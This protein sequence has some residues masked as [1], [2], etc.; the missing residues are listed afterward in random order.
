MSK[1]TQKGTP[2]SSHSILFG[3]LTLVVATL[4][5]TATVGQGKFMRG[6][7]AFF[8]YGGGNMQSADYHF[9]PWMTPNYGD[10]MKSKSHRDNQY[11]SSGRT[12]YWMPTDNNYSSSDNTNFAMPIRNYESSSD[13]TNF[14]MPTNSNDSYSDHTN[15]SMPTGSQYPSSDYSMSFGT[16]YPASDSANYSMSSGSEYSSSDYSNYSMSSGSE[17]SSSEYSSSDYSNYSMPTGSDYSS[18]YGMDSSVT[19]YESFMSSV[20]SSMQNAVD[21]QMSD[22]LRAHASSAMNTMTSSQA[23]LARNLTHSLTLTPPIAEQAFLFIANDL[24]TEPVT[25]QFASSVM[26]DFKLVNGQELKNAGLTPAADVDPQDW[27]A[28]VVAEVQM[29]GIMQGS[30]V[31]GLFYPERLMNQAEFARTLANA[32]TKTSG[33][34]THAAVPLGPTF[35]EWPTWASK[36]VSTLVSYDIASLFLHPDPEDSVTRLQLAEGV[37]T[38]LFPDENTNI[39][40]A[41]VFKDMNAVPQSLRSAVRT[42]SALGLMTGDGTTGKFEPNRLANRAEVAKVFAAALHV[43]AMQAHAAESSP[44]N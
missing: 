38:A 43:K 37:V 40:A 6:E 22:E 15:F 8:P 23:A 29:A 39:A 13:Y 14:S 41:K 21:A 25:P 11:S 2:F 30:P 31:T 19:G 34:A 12:N 42:V 24:S 7:L 20:A 1:Q 27:Y 18:S 28:P 16:E 35:S 33:P 26:Y 32:V 36:A 4:A 17:Y 9:A 44:A 10:M 5:V 3:S